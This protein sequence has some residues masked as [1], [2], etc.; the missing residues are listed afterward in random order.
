V[1]RWGVFVFA[2]TAGVFVAVPRSASEV[3][4]PPASD[5]VLLLSSEVRPPPLPPEV[6]PRPLPLPRLLDLVY[7][8]MMLIRITKVSLGCVEYESIMYF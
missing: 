2:L 4:P 3:R 1:V 5:T 7:A 6:R 8:I